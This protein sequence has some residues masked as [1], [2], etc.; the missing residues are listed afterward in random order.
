MEA[1]PQLPEAL[2]DPGAAGHGG[3]QEGG[4]PLLF[5]CCKTPS[6]AFCHVTSNRKVIFIILL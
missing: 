4:S 2:R 3:G 5:Y 6:F 1:D